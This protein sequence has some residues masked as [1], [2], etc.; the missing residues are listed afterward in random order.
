ML[1]KLLV[2]SRNYITMISV[3]TIYFL[4]LQLGYGKNELNSIIF[5]TPLCTDYRLLEGYRKHVVL[6]FGIPRQILI[7]NY[8]GQ[9]YSE[10]LELLSC[11]NYTGQ[12]YSE[13]FW[14]DR[15]G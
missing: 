4:H 3:F 9:P 5:L 2:R 11:R 7:R 12:L 1:I 13:D 10:L 6:N 14:L 15:V 8:T